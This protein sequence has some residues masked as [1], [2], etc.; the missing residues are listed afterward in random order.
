MSDS[1]G[2]PVSMESE[3]V[4]GVFLNTTE[5]SEITLSKIRSSGSKNLN[6]GHGWHRRGERTAT[7]ISRSYLKVFY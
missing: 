1:T 5:I 4:R 2:V 7:R 6:N 3:I